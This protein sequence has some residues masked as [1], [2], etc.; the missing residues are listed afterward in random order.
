[1]ATATQALQNYAERFGS[2]QN[3]A[4]ARAF[5]AA[6]NCARPVST[7]S[8]KRASRPRAT[9][10][11]AL[12]TFRA[13]RPDEFSAESQRPSRCPLRSR[14]MPIGWRARLASWYLSTAAS[15]RRFPRQ[16][17]AAKGV[18]VGSLAS[19]L[20]S[21]PQ[22]L[23]PYLGRYLDTQRDAFRRAQ[24]RFHRRR[25]VRAYRQGRG[26]GRADSSA[27]RLHRARRAGR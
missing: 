6:A 22:A 12:P 16:A 8:A 26:A 13:D 14:S 11:G 4:Q 1:M 7:A 20:A 15:L 18:R 23:E 10:T 19:L 24:H 17:V 3:P 9:K 2:L 25:R 21:E 5:V 27:V